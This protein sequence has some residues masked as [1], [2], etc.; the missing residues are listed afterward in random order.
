M[1][2]E[3]YQGQEVLGSSHFMPSGGLRTLVILFATFVGCPPCRAQI[4]TLEAALDRWGHNSLTIV[5]LDASEALVVSPKDSADRAASGTKFPAGLVGG[6]VLAGLNIVV[7]PTLFF[8][9]QDGSVSGRWTGNMPAE[10]LDQAIIEMFAAPQ[11][12]GP[13]APVSLDQ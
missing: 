8:V 13:S 3:L 1:R 9:R 10:A 12:E 4:V 11:P 5:A 7:Y 2:M 6:D